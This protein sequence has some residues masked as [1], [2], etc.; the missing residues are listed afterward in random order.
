MA[1]HFFED[2]KVTRKAT[3]TTNRGKENEEKLLK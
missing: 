1:Y 3:T 2:W